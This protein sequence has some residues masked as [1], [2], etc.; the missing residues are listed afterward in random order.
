MLSEALDTHI[1]YDANEARYPPDVL[2]VI[3]VIL[4][5]LIILKV[6]HPG[7]IIGTPMQWNRDVSR[8]PWIRHSVL[9]L[10]IAI[11]SVSLFSILVA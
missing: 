8:M 6:L 4:D 5:A 10:L 1:S 2:D 9:M 7:I 11:S 3:P